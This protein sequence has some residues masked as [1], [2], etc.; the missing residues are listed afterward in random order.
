MDMIKKLNEYFHNNNDNE[1]KNK[2][3]NKELV[4]ND[5]DKN[6]TNKSLL[7][8]LSEHFVLSVIS[9]TVLKKVLLSV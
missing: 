4:L 2:T 1:E 9:F 3:W 5:M 7:S 6:I 8:H